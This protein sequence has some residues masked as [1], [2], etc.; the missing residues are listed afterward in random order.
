[1]YSRTAWGGPVD[2]FI[3]IKFTDAGSTDGDDPIVSLVIFEWKDED[4]I[5]VLPDENAYQVSSHTELRLNAKPS[6]PLTQAD[7]LSSSRKSASAS[8]NTSRQAS[9][10]RRTSASTSWHRTPRQ[11]PKA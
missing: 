4:F 2:P 5:G 1:M 11:N 9:A 8:P 7:H 3:L 6:P 10:T